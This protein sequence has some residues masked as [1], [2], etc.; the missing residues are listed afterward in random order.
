MNTNKKIKIVLRGLGGEEHA[1][2]MVDAE[3]YADA[4]LIERNKRIYIYQ[5]FKIE[6][7]VMVGF[8]N[9]TNQAVVM[10]EI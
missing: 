9:E 8:Y 7:G 2:G 3:K 6:N 1:Q 10:T 5:N 4:Q